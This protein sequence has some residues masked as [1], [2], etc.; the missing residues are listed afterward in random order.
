M[1][2][3]TIQ[4]FD[5]MTGAKRTLEPVCPGRVGIYVCGVTV[6]DLTHIGHARVFVGFDIVTRYLRHRGYEV[7][8]VRNHTDVDDKIINRANERGQDPLELSQHFI[9][10]LDADM[11][12]LGVMTPDVEPKVSTHIEEIVAMVEKLVAN[13]HAYEVNGDVYFEVDTFPAYGKLSGMKLDEM[14]A[15]ERVDVD[16]RK[17]NPADFALWKSQKPGEPAWESPW[18]LGRPGW[19]IECSAMSTTHLGANFDIHGGGKDLV[20]PHHENEIAQSEGA[21]KEHYANMW[22]HVGLVNVDD[23]KMSKSLGNFWTV[24][25]VVALY[26]SEVIRYF[27]LS[28][29]YRK[30]ISYS[31]GNLDLAR[32]RLQYLYTTKDAISEL[33]NRATRPPADKTVLDEFVARLYTGMDDDFNSSVALAVVGDAAKLANELLTTKKLAKKTDVLAKIAAVEELFGV[34]GACF[35]V[36]HS[37]ART[38]LADIRGRL[39]VQLEIDPAYVAG[40]IDERVAA[41]AAK[42]W[43]AGDAI[44][45]ELASMHVELMDRADGT[46]WRIN[47]PEPELA[48]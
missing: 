34:F 46:D 11:G 36:L 48:E 6:Y 22:M 30:P 45:D 39:A 15:G 19:H 38:V 7:K 31:D 29:H 28:A 25:D 10:Q 16:S 9:E 43:A 14:R 4:V 5:T 17:R 33:W 24:R 2:L 26:H 44:R 20:F 12:S 47:P 13:G 8:Y 23:V 40:K 21:C 3:P 32:H 41:R 35:G 27:F 1:A 42:D 18:G 37:D